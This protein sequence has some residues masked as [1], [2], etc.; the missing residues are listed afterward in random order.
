MRGVG[1]PEGCGGRRSCGTV[2][3]SSQTIALVHELADARTQVQN[4]AASEVAR[5]GPEVAAHTPGTAAAEATGTVTT[6]A[7]ETAATDATKTATT[8]GVD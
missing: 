4:H 5:P 3:T 1:P 2:S 7:T 8:D 6:A